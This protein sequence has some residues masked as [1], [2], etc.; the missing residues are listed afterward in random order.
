VFDAPLP[1][2]K[3]PLQVVGPSQQ[4]IKNQKKTYYIFSQFE[5]VKQ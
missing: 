1:L 3:V 4:Q 2:R 5:N